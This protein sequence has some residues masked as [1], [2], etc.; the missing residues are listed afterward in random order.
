MNRLDVA[1]RLI[2]SCARYDSRKAQCF[3]FKVWQGHANA[4][5]LRLKTAAKLIRNQ[6]MA[7]LK[8]RFLRWRTC[9][10]ELMDACRLQ[11]MKETFAQLLFRQAVPP[12]AT[13]NRRQRGQN[14]VV[15]FRPPYQD[16]RCSSIRKHG[17]NGPRRQSGARAMMMI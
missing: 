8:T 3:A 2:L 15:D 14:V 12:V 13:T 16:P 7:V 5:T 9:S 1:S 6:E 10:N 4:R 11:I 17:R